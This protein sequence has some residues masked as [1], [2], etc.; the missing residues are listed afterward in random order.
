MRSRVAEAGAVR[1][2]VPR[3]APEP[4]L[5]AASL[6]REAL[7][8]RSGRPASGTAGSSTRLALPGRSQPPWPGAAP[9]HT[10]CPQPCWWKPSAGPRRSRWWPRGARA[11]R[12][13]RRSARDRLP[14]CRGRR[15]IERHG[16]SP[17]NGSLAA[18]GPAVSLAAIRSVVPWAPSS[19]LEHRTSG[20]SVAERDAARC[21]RVL[22]RR[23]I[24]RAATGATVRSVLAGIRWTRPRIANTAPAKWN[25]PLTVP[26]R[27]S[28]VPAL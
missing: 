25:L 23:G 13:R 22:R 10:S 9:W 3:Y 8:S 17:A 26:S 15:R 19:R 14:I 21:E 7:C 16:A 27:A 6:R 20:R 12:V 2:G 11:R 1:H 5:A 24:R 18:C 28:N 4:G